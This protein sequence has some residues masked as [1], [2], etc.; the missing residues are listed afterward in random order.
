M[1]IAT[2]F[3]LWISLMMKRSLLLETTLPISHVNIYYWSNLHIDKFLTYSN[4]GLYVGNHNT[5]KYINI[6]LE[7]S[8]GPIE[9]SSDD[10]LEI[11]LENE[12]GNAESPCRLLA[13]LSH[14]FVD[15]AGK[16][17]H[18]PSI[19]TCIE[20]VQS[21]VDYSFLNVKKSQSL[22]SNSKYEYDLC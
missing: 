10:I 4:D 18:H 1:K 9:V 5:I 12:S 13:L 14:K 2:I 11:K 15:R 21:I 6:D 20:S 16:T 8:N 3:I 17:A 7:K 19:I 22:N